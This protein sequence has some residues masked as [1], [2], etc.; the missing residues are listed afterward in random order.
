MI[1][2]FRGLVSGAWLGCWYGA[3]T[4]QLPTDSPT[5]C[6]GLYGHVLDERC[7]SSV[8]QYAVLRGAW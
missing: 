3:G 8:S 4:A 5:E 1:A 6:S 2:Y 7:W